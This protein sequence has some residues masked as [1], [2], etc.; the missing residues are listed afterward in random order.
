[1]S[2]ATGVRQGNIQPLTGVVASLVGVGASGGLRSDSRSPQHH[3]T[4]K[5]RRTQP[6]GGAERNQ[7]VIP[8]PSPPSRRA[9]DAY[10]R[11]AASAGETLAR[12]AD[13]ADA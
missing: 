4:R 6:G 5:P 8:F 9:R 13:V 7:S 1:M 2:G 12:E 10:T 3:A 11:E